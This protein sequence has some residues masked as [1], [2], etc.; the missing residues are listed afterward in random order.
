LRPGP[1]LIE[2]LL[3][4]IKRDKFAL[5]AISTIMLKGANVLVVVPYEEKHTESIIKTLKTTKYDF[6]I[7][8]EGSNIIIN[9]G[10][11]PKDVKMDLNKR[12]TKIQN[13]SKDKLK[14]VRQEVITEFKKIEKI[15]GK[16]DAK[17]L[18]KNI[19]DTIE[20]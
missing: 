4:E 5:S 18:E 8:T 20:K 19:T 6:E 14:H 11:I 15:I 10:E 13:D 9:V 16:D 2:N 1:K 3:V 7:S 17:R 12:V